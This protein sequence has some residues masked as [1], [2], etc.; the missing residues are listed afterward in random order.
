[1]DSAG[2]AVEGKWT[3]CASDCG[4]CD[5][6]A[7]FNVDGVC[8]DE[9]E[10]NTIET[11]DAKGKTNIGINERLEMLRETYQDILNGLRRG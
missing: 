6:G 2:E 5:S 11:R 10:K 3:D 7:L 1:L 9:A 8:I 4:V